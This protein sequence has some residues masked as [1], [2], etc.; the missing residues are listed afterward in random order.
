MAR[1]NSQQTVECPLCSTIKEDHTHLFFTYNFA[2]KVWEEL[3]NWWA[4]IP[5]TLN[6]AELLSLFKHKKEPNKS[7]RITGVIMTTAIHN[8]W[9]ARNHDLFKNHIQPVTLTVKGVRSRS[10]TEFYTCIPT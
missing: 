9:R 6:K 10:D 3:R 4:G 1:F 2:R 5:T 8:V 7:K